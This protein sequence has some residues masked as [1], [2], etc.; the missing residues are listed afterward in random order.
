MTALRLATLLTALLVSP[1]TLPAQT[2]APVDSART[3]FRA[4]KYRDAAELLERAVEHDE[5][6]VQY[7]V[8]LGYAY[9][10][11]RERAN[12]LKVPG[13]AAKSRAHFERAVTLDSSN[14]DARVGLARKYLYTP[15]IGGGS[16]TK[17]R[18]QADAVRRLSPYRGGLLDA[19]I[20]SHTG[21]EPMARRAL[22]ALRVEY[23]DSLAPI[24]RLAELHL[25]QRQRDSA[26]AVLDERLVRVPGDSVTRAARAR[27]AP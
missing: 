15:R 20:A 1:A 25:R 4:Q 5:S 23:P 10:A 19:E 12:V 17:A 26:L 7:H 24:L 3:L 14:I 21:A 6:N 11:L 27:I 16:V 13:Y 8:W 2:R 9:D 18:A 22:G